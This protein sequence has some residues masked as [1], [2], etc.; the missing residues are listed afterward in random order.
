MTI[1]A[2]AEDLQ[3]VRNYHFEKADLTG[4][5]LRGNELSVV[6]SDGKSNGHENLSDY[7]S[8]N[9]RPGNGLLRV[10]QPTVY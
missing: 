8:T 10:D 7:Y 1:T 5:V 4:R 2:R 3:E 6:C 9:R